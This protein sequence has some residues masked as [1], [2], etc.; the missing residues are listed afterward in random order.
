MAFSLNSCFCNS[1][2]VK[3]ELTGTAPLMKAAGMIPDTLYA[4]S[5]VVADVNSFRFL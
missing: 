3:Y 4:V 5:G 2:T 1:A